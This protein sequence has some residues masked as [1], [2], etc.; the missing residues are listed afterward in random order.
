MILAFLPNPGRRIFFTSTIKL[1]QGKY[2][3]PTLE[4]FLSQA[5]NEPPN[6]WTPAEFHTRVATSTWAFHIHPS[7]CAPDQPTTNTSFLRKR[8]RGKCALLRFP[9]TH[10]G[11]IRRLRFVV[12]ETDIQ[13][14][15]LWYCDEKV[16]NLDSIYAPFPLVKDNPPPFSHHAW[17]SARIFWP[18]KLHAS[19]WQEVSVPA[20]RA[21]RWWRLVFYGS[22]WWANGIAL[23][24]EG[25]TM[26]KRQDMDM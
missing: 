13:E 20:V 11:I 12:G 23:E 5:Q 17:R 26:R 15:E 7:L 19:E 25:L 22:E 3:D 16:L 10:G 8:E 18:S 4:V 9:M 1:K 14:I 6:D 24:F 21:S 2:C